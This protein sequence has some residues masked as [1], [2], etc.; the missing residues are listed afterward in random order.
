MK[1]SDHSQLNKNTSYGPWSQ[2]PL[3]DEV[4]THFKN[5]THIFINHGLI[6]ML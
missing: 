1:I 4:L 5:L 6:E 3:R 2:I